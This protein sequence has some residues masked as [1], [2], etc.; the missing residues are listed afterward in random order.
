MSGS[1][2]PALYSI[3]SIALLITI[4]IRRS[5]KNNGF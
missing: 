5:R 4:A 3:L 1:I 2:F